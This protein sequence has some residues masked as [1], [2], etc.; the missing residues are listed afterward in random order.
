MSSSMK[1]INVK[2]RLCSLFFLWLILFTQQVYA[3]RIERL[4]MPGE[5][6]QGHQKF[7]DECEKCHL[8]FTKKA[9][10]ELCRDCHEDIDHDVKNTRG[11]HGDTVIGNRA[12]TDCHTDHEGRSA[13]IILFEADT[14]NHKQTDFELKGKHKLL[15][16]DSCH[17]AEKK[18]R[19]A[20]TECIDCHKKDEPHEQLLGK[21]CADCHSEDTWHKT[22]FD[23]QE[24]DFPLKHKHK[25]VS[26]ESCHP[27]NISKQIS[28]QCIT[29]HLI[30][31]VHGE[32]YGRKCKDCHSSKGWKTVKFNHDKETDFA[33][34]GS[35]KKL[36]CGSCHSGNVYKDK[37]KTDCYSCHKNNDEHR[38]QYGHQ[39]EDCHQSGKWNTVKFNHDKTDFLLKGKHKDISCHACHRGDLYEEE[40]KTNCY[41]C[42][43]Q[44]DVHKKSE[45]DQCENCHNES[46]WNERVLFEHDMT[47]FPLIGLH[48]VAPCEQCHVSHNYKETELACHACHQPDDV[49][50]KKL[51]IDCMVCH[52]PNSWG[53]WQFDHNK[54]TEYKLDGKH[55]GLACLACHT[56]PQEDISLGT[57]CI[58]CHEKDDIHEG[59]FTN[60]CE[61]CHATSSFKDITLVR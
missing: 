12:C 60:Y 52:N 23:H 41:G 50:E 7:E 59:R 51:G 55:E 11:F 36:S 22:E 10:T 2:N 9:Q 61:R 17:I 27:A 31:D 39:C 45:G 3:L 14:F 6:I 8:N 28:T 46:G 58:D 47:K 1:L 38:G 4:V 13:R 57:A 54:Q 25:E 44:D 35:H 33:L 29:C 20:K 21:Q 26:C 19:E 48:A 30:N 43:Q 49:H 53:I 24:T 16:C 56:K 5:L 15:N 34:K 40:L 42:H 18:Y 37:L 32:R